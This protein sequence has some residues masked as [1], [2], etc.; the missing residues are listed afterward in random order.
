MKL[1]QWTDKND[2][3]KRSRLKIVVDNIEFLEP[4]GRPFEAVRVDRWVRSQPMDSG[5]MGEESFESMPAGP[6][7]EPPPASRPEEDIPF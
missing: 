4:K 3:S 5:P 2:G 7:L 6:A 1:D